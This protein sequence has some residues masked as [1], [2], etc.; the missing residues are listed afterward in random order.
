MKIGR[1]AGLDVH[2]SD[3]IKAYQNKILIARGLLLALEEAAQCRF[4]QFKR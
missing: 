1:E 3:W 4:P 2:R